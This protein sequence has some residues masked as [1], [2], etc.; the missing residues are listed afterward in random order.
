MSIMYI[1]FEF[2]VLGCVSEPGETRIEWVIE[3]TSCS[4]YLHKDAGFRVGVMRFN[5]FI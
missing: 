4:L 5:L 3:L 1:I 2:M